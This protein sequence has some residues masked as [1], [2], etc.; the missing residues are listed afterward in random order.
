MGKV[1]RR[2]FL[3]GLGCAA[4][5]LTAC[6]VPGKYLRPVTGAAANTFHRISRESEYGPWAAELY[7][8]TAKW[9]SGQTVEG[10]TVLYLP[11][12]TRA[13]MEADGFIPERW[14]C[15]VTAERLFDANGD[16]RLINGV[17]CA[18]CLTPGGLAI[19]GGVQGALGS[20]GE[21]SFRA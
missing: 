5:A 2:N 10:E 3:K 13:A 16:L 17:G 11:F 6:S 20:M 7:L 15:L 19:E 4:A 18:T 14:I 9:N 8:N 1:N 12:G 21:K